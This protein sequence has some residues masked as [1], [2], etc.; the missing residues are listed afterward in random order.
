MVRQDK[1]LRM[2]RQDKQL[3]MVRQDKQLR[4]VHQDKQLR[5]VQ[6]DKQLRMVRQDRAPRGTALHNSKACP[7]Q[8]DLLRMARSRILKGFPLRRLNPHVLRAAAAALE[9]LSPSWGSSA[10]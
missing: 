8:V 4:M 10:F 9:S 3:R 5:M 1:Q 7:F 6:Q 2:V